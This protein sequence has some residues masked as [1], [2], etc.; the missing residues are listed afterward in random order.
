MS[1]AQPAVITTA[2]FDYD[3]TQADTDA[4]HMACWSDTSHGHGATIELRIDG[5][6]PSFW[7]A[8]SIRAPKNSAMVED[9][10]APASRCA[11]NRWK[12]R[13]GLIWVHSELP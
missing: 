2:L 10:V 6:T 7:S 3:G 11:P 13:D 8:S 4:V 12:Q 1:P 9:K 5:T